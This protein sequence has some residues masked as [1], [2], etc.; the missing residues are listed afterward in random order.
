MKK[1]KVK[2]MLATIV[3]VLSSLFSIE[4]SMAAGRAIMLSPMNQKI[5]LNPGETYHASLIVANPNNVEADLHYLATL[6]TY[7]PT[8]IN[9]DDKYYR[10]SDFE[11]KSSMNMIVDWT[12]I[13]NPTGILL[14]NEEQ[15]ISFTIKVP[16]TAPA[17]GQ[18]MAIIVRED[19]EFTEKD[20]DSVS[21]KEI[22]QMAHIVYAEVAGETR[23]EGTILENTIPSFLV[24]NTLEA[25]SAVRN[26]GNVHTDA[27]FILQVWPM[28]SDEELCTNEENAA[29]GFVMPDTEIYHV[30]TCQLPPVGIFKAKQT[31]KIFGETSIVEKTVIVCPIWLLF[32]IIFAIA[33]III[34]FIA[35]ARKRNIKKETA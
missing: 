19:P 33:T 17:G 4:Q 7:Y 32:I 21:V 25:S 27:E 11:T 1:N 3:I 29:T 23:K 12:E 28:G 2:L 31:V 9:E 14:P 24:Y 15:Q 16:E 26:N 10:G 6:S 22:M 5:V 13:E 30:E 18:Y 20:D 35:K 34:Y 8:K